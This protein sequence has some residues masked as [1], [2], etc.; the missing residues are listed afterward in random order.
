MDASSAG[1]EPEI[2]LYPNIRYVSLRRSL[3]A[4]TGRVP[5]SRAQS[6]G[7]D[8]ARARCGAKADAVRGMDREAGGGS[9]CYL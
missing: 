6:P 3:Q 2:E 9:A 8:R 4:A 7:C 1:K 5:V